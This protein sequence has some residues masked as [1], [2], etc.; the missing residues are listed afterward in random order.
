MKTQTWRY[1]QETKKIRTVPENYWV[2]TMDSWDGSLNHE[3]NAKLIAAAP[4]MLFALQRAVPWLSKMIA[5]ENHL[6]CVSPNDAVNTL[7]LI[8]EII[9]EL[10]EPSRIKE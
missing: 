4:K 9:N 10:N 2:A 8:K 7:E 1:E 3:L 6:H 5:D